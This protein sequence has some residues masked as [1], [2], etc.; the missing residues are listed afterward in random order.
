MSV[1]WR[2]TR[3]PRS[4]FV[5]PH[6]LSHLSVHRSFLGATLIGLLLACATPTSSFAPDPDHERRVLLLERDFLAFTR[7]NLNATPASLS[8][9]VG[10]IAV[11]ELDPWLSELESLRLRYLQIAADS[12]SERHRLLALVR[13]AELHLDLGARV[14]RIPYPVGATQTERILFDEELSRVA[15]PLEIVGLSVLQQVT[16]YAVRVPPRVEESRQLVA[17]CELYLALHREHGA[18]M[19]AAHLATLSRELTQRN[20]FPAPKTLLEVG[21]IG[22]RAAR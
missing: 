4:T 14:R 11:L 13:I 16:D 3:T 5:R 21:R 22:Q 9:A 7:R 8:G 6:G 18:R 1:N 19:D 10:R 2:W 17:R 20:V 15:L 12:V